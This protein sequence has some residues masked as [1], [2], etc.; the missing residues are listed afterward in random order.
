[1]TVIAPTI[2]NAL[3]EHIATSLLLY[4]SVETLLEL[5]EIIGEREAYIVPGRL[6]RYE[7]LLSVYLK[8]PIFAGDIEKV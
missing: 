3:S 4:C 6:T 1:M 7:I 8:L 2:R 5:N